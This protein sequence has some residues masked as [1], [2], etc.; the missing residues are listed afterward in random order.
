MSSTAPITLTTEP[1]PRTPTEHTHTYTH[2]ISSL[3]T[4]H[5][6]QLQRPR[7]PNSL[8]YLLIAPT[9][10]HL[11]RATSSFV[12]TPSHAPQP[13]T[14]ARSRVFACGGPP[15]SG[16]QRLITYSVPW[17]W[18]RLIV[19]ISVCP[20][21]YNGTLHIFV[22][23][24]QVLCVPLSMCYACA[25]LLLLFFCAGSVAMEEGLALFAS[26]LPLHVTKAS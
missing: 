25:A 2:T 18:K 8:P 14:P 4:T 13:P 15:G 3:P 26:R 24:S 20:P 23:E 21:G 11:S 10:H 19:I 5:T 22:Y 6:E 1:R 7:Y 16:V 9:T 12:P 17:S